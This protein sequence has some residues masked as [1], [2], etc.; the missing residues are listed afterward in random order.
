MTGDESYHADCFTCRQCS[1]RIEEL[2]FAKTSQGIYCMVSRGSASKPSRPAVLTGAIPTILPQTCHNER[3]AR[4]RRHAEAKQRARAKKEREKERDKDKEKERVRGTGERPAP[5]TSNPGAMERSRADSAGGSQPGKSPRPEALSGISALSTPAGLTPSPSRHGFIGI[6]EPGGASATGDTVQLESPRL[7]AE[8]RRDEQSRQGISL[9]R[10]RHSPSPMSTTRRKLSPGV[11]IDMSY[12][13]GGES[14]QGSASTVDPERPNSRNKTQYS[15][16]SHP[17]SSEIPIGLGVGLGG[18]LST[19]SST[20][21]DKRSSINPEMVLNYQQQQHKEEVQ[22]ASSSAPNSSNDHFSGRSSPSPVVESFSAGRHS[23]LPNSPLRA[24]FTDAE[25]RENERAG[26]RSTPHAGSPT[27]KSYP[28]SSSRLTPTVPAYGGPKGRSPITR[29]SSDTGQA[30]DTPPRSSSL[31]DSLDT[32]G[33]SST[34]RVQEDSDDATIKEK[35]VYQRAQTQ[36]Q[37]ANKSLPPQPPN[38]YEPPRIDAPAWSNLGFSLS[39]PDFAKLLAENKASPEKAKQA[40]AA[41][42]A[43]PGRSRLQTAAGER[44]TPLQNSAKAPGSNS[45]PASPVL[46]HSPPLQAIMAA[47]ASDANKITERP[48]RSDSLRSLQPTLANQHQSSEELVTD[49]SELKIP[50]LET[51]IPTLQAVLASTATASAPDG[52]IVIQKAL[53]ERVVNEIQ[54]LTDQVTVLKDKYSGARVSTLICK[55]HSRNR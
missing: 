5:I 48:Q 3:V 39:D 53:L 19:L 37:P 16:G 7:E 30:S 17:S 29:A 10:H 51:S 35:T 23:P 27:L 47:Y 40:F 50:A 49:F 9:D 32:L 46:G 13:S 34:D 54:A 36:D 22:S 38:L 24:S 44:V 52:S 2:V 43:S 11:E 18:S 28:A 41:R 12:Y 26:S 21:A 20:R 14:G 25:A 8:S 42:E 33:G 6:P 15:G 55:V 1:R 4:S 45:L 31:T